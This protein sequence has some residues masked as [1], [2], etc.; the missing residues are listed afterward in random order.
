MQ[1]CIRDSGKG[2]GAEPGQSAEPDAARAIQVGEEMCIR[3]RAT[4]EAAAPLLALGWLDA[5]SP[6]TLD[7]LFALHTLSL[8]HI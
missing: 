2:E 1:M 6:M 5:D 3:D 7:E 4:A 8:I